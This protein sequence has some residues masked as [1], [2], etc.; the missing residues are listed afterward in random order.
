MVTDPKL[1]E[2]LSFWGIDAMKMEKTDKTFSEMEVSMNLSYDWS[3]L[4]EGQEK[5]EPIYGP[6]YVGLS[7]IGSSCYMNSVLQAVLSLPEVF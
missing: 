1:A 6:G 2:H 7:N 3:K 5:L 4:L